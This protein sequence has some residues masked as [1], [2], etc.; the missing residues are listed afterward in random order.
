MMEQMTDTLENNITATLVPERKRLGF[1]PAKLPKDYL[2]FERWVFDFAGNR[3]GEESEK[4]SYWD[5]MVLSNGG[6][7]LRPAG[8]DSFSISWWDN[9]FQGIVSADA[10]GIIVTL[11]AL[12]RLAEATEEDAIITYYYNLRDYASLHPEASMIYRAID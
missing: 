7:Y 4:P 2:R 11:F 5:F 6:F 8:H 3:V 10:F 1:L 12:C 9:D